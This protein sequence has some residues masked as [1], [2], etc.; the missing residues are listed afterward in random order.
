MKGYLYSTHK[1]CKYNSVKFTETLLNYLQVA[2]EC[3]SHRTIGQD[4]VAMCVNDVL[5][6]GARPLYFLDYFASGKLEVNV[7][8]EV[9]AGIAEACK[10]AGCALVGMYSAYINV[11]LAVCCLCLN[12]NIRSLNLAHICC[13]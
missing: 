7:A 9:I 2:M 13:I 10:I 6:H 8:T 11:L 5:C 1:F 3:L 12:R 4:L